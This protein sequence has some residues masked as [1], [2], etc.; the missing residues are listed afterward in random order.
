[1]DG[2]AASIAA[3]DCAV[4]LAEDG[5]ATLDILRVDVPA[6]A[7][8][9]QPAEGSPDDEDLAETAAVIERAEELLGE[10]FQK[11]TVAGDP[12]RSI[13]EVATVGGY[14]LVVMGTH[15]RVGRLHSMLGSVAEGVVRNAP[16][17]VLT[18]REPGEQYQSFAERRHG[19]PTL[20]ERALRGRRPHA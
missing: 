14:N 12:L 8:A 17:P 3:L 7:A 6:E 2:S 9:I 18:V 11:R 16:C 15:G 13:V 5:D 4:A 10:K 19:T 1:M 20:V